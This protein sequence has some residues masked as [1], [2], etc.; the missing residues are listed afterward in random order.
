MGGGREEGGQEKDLYEP[1]AKV[2]SQP[3]VGDQ[4]LMLKFLLFSMIR[5]VKIHQILLYS[6]CFSGVCL[7]WRT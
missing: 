7:I 4:N 6:Y 1:I 2:Y 3:V 5:A